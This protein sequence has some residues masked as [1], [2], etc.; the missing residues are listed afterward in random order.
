[1]LNENT[2]IKLEEVKE[3][4]SEDVKANVQMIVGD[5]NAEIIA[6][7]DISL[8]LDGATVQ[9]GGEVEVTL[10]IPENATEYS[11]LQVVYIDDEGKATPCETR[12]NEDGTLTF[13][14]D[15]FSYYAI[16][17]VSET[18]KLVWL[19]ISVISVV[20]IA[21][22]VVAVLFIRKNTIA[23]AK[24]QNDVNNEIG[25]NSL[26]EET[27]EPQNEPEDEVAEEISED[28]TDN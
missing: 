14:T 17:G 18:S 3:E 8:M 6:A 12:V 28:Q 1:V 22:A 27:L 16:I 19:L 20:L 13:V 23:N 26:K 24:V 11:K 21:S 5:G 10:P 4:T 2:V 15:H 7:Y 25:E 9:P